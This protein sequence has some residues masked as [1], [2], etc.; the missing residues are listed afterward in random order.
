MR[1]LLFVTLLVACGSPATKPAQPAMPATPGETSSAPA[2]SPAVAAPAPSQPARQFRYDAKTFFENVRMFGASFSHDGSRVLLSSDA[3]GVF[4]VYA[5]PVAGGAPT[6]LTKSTKDSHFAI[7]YFPQDDRY[8]YSV[9]GGGN[10]LT[11]IFVAETDGTTKDLTPGDKVKAQ[12]RGFTKDKQAFFV[13]TNER[14]PKFFDL[15]R[16]ATKGYARTLVFQNDGYHIGPIS[17]DGRWLALG[18]TIDNADADIYLVDLTAKPKAGKAVAPKL[19]TKHTGKIQHRPFDFTPDSKKLVYSTDG[20]GEFTQAWSYDVKSGKATVEVKADWDVVAVYYSEN[21]KYRVSITNDDARSVLTVTDVKKKQP[22]AVKDLPAGDIVDADFDRAEKQ[23]A[24]YLSSDR[25]PSDLYVVDL[26]SGAPK[27]LSN[28][29]NPKIDPAHLVEAQVVRYKSFDGLDIPAILYKPQGAGPDARVPAIVWVH[30]GPGG[31]SRRGYSDTLQYL[32]HRGYAVLAVNNRGSSGYGKTFFHMDDKKH[33]DVDLKDCVFGRT[34]LATLDWVDGGKVAIMG[35]SYGGYMT[36]AA[37]AFEPDAFD[38]GI[39]IF[40]VTN[41]VR[42]LESIPPWWAA[43]RDALYA[44]LGNPATD[45][46]RLTAISPLF[47]AKN[48]KKPL[49][50]VQGANDPRVI[51][52]E[53]DEIVAAVKKNGVPV[54]YLVFDD[55][56]HGFQKRKNNISAAERYVAFLD[57]YL[58]GRR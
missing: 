49:L 39:D 34:Y 1:T 48:I 3:T 25:T 16:Y 8:L 28:N 32:V 54:E 15:Y 53:S 7:A 57:R 2:S 13:S 50:V 9:D 20:I 56:G 18:K 10:E 6:Q 23:M 45:K 51:K 26:A 27:R 40:G 58:V 55:E 29:L 30:G 11:H 47:H 43:Q 37:L 44:E 19:I 24:I 35:G 4:N 33:G 36:A 14:D 22:V 31:Q 46:E 52:P 38:A 5:Q 41:W 17:A 12:F 42:T 21:G